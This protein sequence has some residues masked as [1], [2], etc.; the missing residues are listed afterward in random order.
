MVF[1]VCGMSGPGTAVNHQVHVVE[2][3]VAGDA[4]HPQR[5]GGLFAARKG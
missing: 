1:A 4:K 5:K 3:L 2:A